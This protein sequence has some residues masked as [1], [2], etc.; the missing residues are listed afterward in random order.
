MVGKPEYV[1][2]VFKTYNIDYNMKDMLAYIKLARRGRESMAY[3][4]NID[5]GG[6]LSQ[7]GAAPLKTSREEKNAWRLLLSWHSESSWI[8]W[9]PSFR[10]LL[11]S[12]ENTRGSSYFGTTGNFNQYH[13]NG[14]LRLLRICFWMVELLL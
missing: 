14:V 13:M 8:L 5:S 2:K 4:G 10:E 9:L 6:F 11:N 1:H 12:L 3:I 7:K